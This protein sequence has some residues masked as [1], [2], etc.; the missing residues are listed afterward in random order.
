M[1]LKMTVEDGVKV[2]AFA[3][4][5]DAGLDLSVTE[6]IELHPYNTYMAGTGIRVAIPKGYYGE[7]VMRS[8]FA[9]KNNVVLANGTGIIDASYRGEIKLP[10]YTDKKHVVRIPKG[11]RVAQLI[12]HKIPEVEVE[13]VDELDDTERGEGGFGSSGR[14]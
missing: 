10:L 1:K 9:T 2:P 3:H 8:G 6:Y 12:L 13:V 7:V 11:E 4:D 5:T 14:M